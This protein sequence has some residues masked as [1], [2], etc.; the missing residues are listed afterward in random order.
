M[1]L[2]Y[3]LCIMRNKVIKI[4]AKGEIIRNLCKEEPPK[5]KDNS[6]TK[7][8]NVQKIDETHQQRTN[9]TK[10]SYVVP[11]IRQIKHRNL[12]KANFQN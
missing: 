11:K 1:A 5:R 10:T 6:E 8:T 3:L 12:L 4:A 7:S 2:I 9:N